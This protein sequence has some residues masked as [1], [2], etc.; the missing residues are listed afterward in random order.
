MLER[1]VCELAHTCFHYFLKILKT[2]DDRRRTSAES[3]VWVELI[4]ITLRSSPLNLNKRFIQTIESK[5]SN[6]NYATTPIFFEFK[7]RE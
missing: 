7:C 2:E 5:C 3:S 4:Y 1:G 6:L